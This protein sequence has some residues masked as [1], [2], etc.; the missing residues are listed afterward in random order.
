MQNNQSR[1][2][3]PTAPAGCWL[4]YDA[5]NKKMPSGQEARGL[6]VTVLY[7]L[8]LESPVSIEIQG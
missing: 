7:D 4:F 5:G 6:N 1:L 8:P 2:P 3:A